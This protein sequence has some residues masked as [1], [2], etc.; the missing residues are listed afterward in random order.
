[1]TV[2]PSGPSRRVE[3]TRSKDAARLALTRLTPG[4]GVTLADVF[5][6]AC[7]LGA[8]AL[9]VSRATVWLMVEEGRALRCVDLY[10]RASREH[11]HGTVMR[12]AD[13]PQY[14]AALARRK[15]LPAESALEDARTSELV[16]ALPRAA[17]DHLAPGC[18]DS[19]RRATSWA[20]SVSS[21]RASRVSGPRRSAT[22]PGRWPI[23]LAL[24]LRAAE[25][26]KLQS[27]VRG[28]ER[29]LIGLERAEAV[30]QLAAG[31][32]HDFG[33]LLMVVSA[34]AAVLLESGEL[35]TRNAQ[36]VRQLDQAA[37]RGSALISELRRLGGKAAGKPALV[38]VAAAVTESLPLLRVLGGARHAVEVLPTACRDRTLIE[39]GR[40]S[41]I[42]LNLVKNACEAMPDGG[43]VEVSVTAVVT[44]EREGDGLAPYIALAVRDGGSGIPP[45]LAERIFDPYY[46]TK[47]EG[48]GLG[49]AIV[50]SLVDQAGGFI[51]MSSEPGDGLHVHRAAAAGERE[52]SDRLRPRPTAP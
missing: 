19:R 48:T 36:L 8:E 4:D 13:F 26:S 27:V 44:E 17:R 30:S 40:L 15:T 47:P 7:E 1:M 14:F 2:K 50:R 49:L 43:R 16:A 10:E 42:L 29:R 5:A 41:R 31:V 24:K 9:R 37:E 18:A 22:S 11:S 23:L 34:T 21:I 20:S 45:D 33:N 38:D 3:P 25:V 35:G 46:T 6:R 12:L 32:A 39:R 28:H 51:R 52:L